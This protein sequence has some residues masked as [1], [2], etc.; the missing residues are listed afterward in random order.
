[1]LSCD[2]V[3]EKDGVNYALTAEQDATNRLSSETYNNGATSW[4]M[5]DNA[6]TANGYIVVAFKGLTVGQT[7]K[8]SMTWDNNAALDSGY[9][10]RVA[11]KNGAADE[12]DTNFTHWNKTNGSSETLTGVFYCTICK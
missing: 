10:H 9:Q 11:H 7:Y 4:Q 3:T 8:I 6:G 12:N 1:M 5:V 2:T